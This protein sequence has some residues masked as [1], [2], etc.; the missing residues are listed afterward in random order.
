MLSQIFKI[1]LL[2]I[3]IAIVFN[4]YIPNEAYKNHQL[5]VE[6]RVDDLLSR[7]TLA[8]KIEQLG[9]N[10]FITLN[11]SRLGIPGFQMA[12]GPAGIRQDTSL[13]FPCGIALASSWDTVLL[14]KVGKALAVEARSRGI[15]IILAPLINMARIPQGGRNFENFGEDPFLVSRM[16][17]SFINGMQSEKVMACAK[18][19][20]CNDQEWNRF[21]LNTIVDEQALNEIY[22]YPFRAAVCEAKVGTIMTAYNKVNG[23][24]SSENQY[25]LTEILRKQWGFKGMVMSDWGA[26]KS[27]FGSITGICNL[28]MPN[29]GQYHPEQIHALLNS[30]K[31]SLAD[32]D[33]AVRP[34]LYT[35][36][37]L[38]LLDSDYDPKHLP[39]IDRPLLNKVTL[40]AAHKSI[41]LLRNANNDL[42]LKISPGLKVAI[43]GEL[44]KNTPTGGGGS[45][46][47][48]SIYKVNA[49]D[50]LLKKFD[51][52]VDVTYAQGY[53]LSQE[54][55][56]IPSSNLLTPDGTKHGL[57][58][59]YFNNYTMKG[60]PLKIVVDS[61]L[62]FKWENDNLPIPSKSWDSPFSARWRGKLVADVSG[63]YYLDLCTTSGGR[64]YINN[65]LCIDDMAMHPTY[66]A[67]NEISLI[68]GQPVNI[69]VE[70]PNLWGKP[71]VRLGWRLKSN[72]IA[73]AAAIREKAVNLA[74]K[75]DVVLLF[76]GIDSNIEFE[77]IDRP[78]DLNLPAFQNELIESVAAVNKKT[79]VILSGG[80]PIAMSRW[81]EKCSAILE[82]WYLGQEAGNAIADVLLG[83]YNPSGRLATTI[84]YSAS[85]LPMLDVSNP[86]D[87]IARYSEGLFIGYRY[88]DKYGT[89]AL[90]PFGHGLSYTSF[91]FTNLTVSIP[92]DSVFIAS[93]SVTNTGKLEGTETVQLYV[94]L[95][96]SLENSPLKE[97]KAFGQV[98]LK[99]GE[100]KQVLL[101]FKKEQLK[102][103]DKYKHQWCLQPGKIVI[104]AGAS[105]G[106]IRLSYTIEVK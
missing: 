30:G 60:K 43:I 106:V 91:T 83:L 11:N 90:Y 76:A 49:W 104:M 75:S 21:K 25:L 9:G 96:V 101:P 103:F 29:A 50:A 88:I 24:F 16:A 85:D 81:A 5:P 66:T 86:D 59:E 14:N 22:L 51:Q 87:P 77:G 45:G 69:I 36:I 99:P 93:V 80:T 13:H 47:V 19:F 57:Q 17:V 7:M 58:A 8:E 38:G 53:D 105:A 18:S 34:I 82:T 20:V 70:Y 32:I 62:N 28:E 3:S 64:L 95:P 54:F 67:S 48:R 73:A 65:R 52:N 100:T 92:N 27:T 41:V 33:N 40:D 74:S 26:M 94:K 31:I 35:K 78:L 89:H 79:I 23:I 15:N 10:G 2:L 63:I 61:V 68:K 39:T 1:N 4:G 37:V 72:V 56:A 12:D 71:E 42:P 102:Y 46:S 44:A 97:L 98:L 6:S 84:P 55:C